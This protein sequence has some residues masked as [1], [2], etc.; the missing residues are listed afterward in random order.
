[1]LANKLG[2]SWET[3]DGF[4]N[5]NYYGSITQSSTLC[6]GLDEQGKQI[7]LPLNQLLPMVNPNDLIIHGWDISSVNLAEA[8]KRAKVLDIDLQ[9]Q[10]YCHMETMQPM[11]GIYS[12]NFIA[13]NQSSRVDNIISGT[14]SVQISKLRDQIRQFKST[15]S[16]DKVIVLWTANTERFCDVK[17]GL[18]DTGDNLLNSIERNED[19]ISPSTLYAV[20]SI[21]E[22]C[23]YINGS[24]QNTF[25]PG[26]I[27]LAE[28]H[29]VFIAGD[30][31]KSGNPSFLALNCLY[32]VTIAFVNSE[33]SC[34]FEKLVRL[35][36]LSIPALHVMYSQY[37]YNP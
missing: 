29:H 1:M 25:V 19:E 13:S 21:L 6:L 11:P 4:V 22:G 35:L 15:N 18:N 33:Y 12:E 5:A 28:K 8:M 36:D 23:H 7:Y 3:K 17:Q 31:F 27:D 34:G 32:A 14:K 10:L 30:D 26:V 20:A 16:L 2:L 37:R 24:P 9:K